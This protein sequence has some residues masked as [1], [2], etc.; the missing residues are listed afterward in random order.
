MAVAGLQGP[1]AGSMGGRVLGW[2]EGQAESYREMA[3]G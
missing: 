2:G 3:S 1:Q